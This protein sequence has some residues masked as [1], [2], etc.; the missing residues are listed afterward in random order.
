MEGSVKPGMWWISCEV[1]DRVPLVGP[2]F[3]ALSGFETRDS[4]A[5]TIPC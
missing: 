2:R 5:L 3:H 4:L 1:S